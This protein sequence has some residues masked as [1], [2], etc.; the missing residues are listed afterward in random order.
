EPGKISGSLIC[1]HDLLIEH[2]SFHPCPPGRPIDAA[3]AYQLWGRLEPVQEG[4]QVLRGKSCARYDKRVEFQEMRRRCDRLRCRVVE[5]CKSGGIDSE[6]FQ[7]LQSLEFEN[8][9]GPDFQSVNL[10]LNAAWP[11]RLQRQAVSNLG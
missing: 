10:V 2:L 3:G 9:L 11:N 8:A 4:D 6:F 1:R 5:A 7:L